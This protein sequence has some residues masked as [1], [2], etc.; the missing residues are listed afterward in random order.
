MRSLSKCF[1]NQNSPFQTR[2]HRWQKCLKSYFHQTFQKIRPKKRKFAEDD[3]GHLLERRK[4][5]KSEMATT[6]EMDKIEIE[7]AL[8][9]EDTHYEKV[10]EHL[11]HITGENEKIN[12]HGIWKTK[13]K[14]LLK[15]KPSVPMAIKDKSG[16]LITGA[17]PMKKL[18]LQMFLERLRK[19]PM[20]PELKRLQI[21]KMK[22]AK[23]RLILAKKRK[24]PSWTM[25]EIE[26][27]I[28]SLKNNKCRDPDGLIKRGSTQREALA[29]RSVEQNSSAYIFHCNPP[30]Y[31]CQNDRTDEGF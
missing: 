25:A 24:T 14:I 10:K 19:R 9:I 3:A 26:K 12:T 27:A 18:I 22:L 13:N 7:I 4:K 17:E 20:H 15:Q 6:E 8:K 21:M 23:K 28:K 1:E 29:T 31:W 2:A 11:G 16:N 30:Q 5:M